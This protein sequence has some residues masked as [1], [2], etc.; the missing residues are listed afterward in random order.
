[1]TSCRTLREP[2][3]LR[4]EFVV[5]IITRIWWTESWNCIIVVVYTEYYIALLYDC[6]RIKMCIHDSCV[7]LCYTKTKPCWQSVVLV[8]KKSN[9]RCCWQI[10]DAD[11]SPHAVGVCSKCVS[12]FAESAPLLLTREILADTACMLSYIR[13]F[14]LTLQVFADT[15]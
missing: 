14:L 5:Y 8:G 10:P 1:M 6:M 13:G 9:N 12:I 7:I 15:A 4:V 11:Q 3:S 2:N